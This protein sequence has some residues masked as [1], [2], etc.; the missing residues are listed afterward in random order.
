MAATTVIES[1]KKSARILIVC[2]IRPDGDSLG[3]GFALKKVAEKLGK[4]V[5]FVT[6]SD[7]PSHYSF[8]KCFYE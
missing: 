2:H 4:Q 6:D 5:D 3:S 1:I 7:R 8:I